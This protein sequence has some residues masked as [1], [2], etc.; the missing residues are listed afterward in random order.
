M[1]P[2]QPLCPTSSPLVEDGGVHTVQALEDGG[3]HTVQA[4][5]YSIKLRNIDS[6]L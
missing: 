6:R 2:A 5:G 4:L 3:V 1:Y